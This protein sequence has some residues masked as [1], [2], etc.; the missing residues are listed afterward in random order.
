MPDRKPEAWERGAA[1][2]F[3]LGGGVIGVWEQGKLVRM[4]VYPDADDARS[5]AERLAE[6]RG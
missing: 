5:A 2:P 4:T 6:A 1:A 3:L